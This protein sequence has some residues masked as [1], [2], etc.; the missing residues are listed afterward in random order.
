MKRERSPQVMFPDY[1]IEK[2]AWAWTVI[3]KSDHLWGLNRREQSSHIPDALFFQ[4]LK[5][6][7][8]KA[9]KL[10]ENYLKTC[11]LAK[12]WERIIESQREALEKVWRPVEQ[13]YFKTIEAIMERPMYTD[14]FYCYI[15]S[16]YMCPYDVEA[17]MFIAS[18]W[19]NLPN[20][21]TTIGHEVMHLQFLCNYKKYLQKKGLRVSQIEDL[22]EALT[23]L[24]NEPEF[25]GILLSRD[26]GYP[27]HQK[28]RRWLK[29]IWSKEKD[30]QKF[31]DRAIREI[32]YIG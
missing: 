4:M 3:V 15:T 12:D 23:F 6:S 5:S 22:K 7:F 26:R 28:M 2:D 20:S 13:K 21:I 24:L 11:S 30:F 9:Q 27:E 25:Q 18:M 32:Y 8:P 19:H 16:G 1:S 29:K 17:D 10:A 14:R 31:L